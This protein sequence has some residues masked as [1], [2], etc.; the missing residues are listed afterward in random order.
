MLEVEYAQL[1][2]TGR[3]RDHNEDCIGHFVPRTPDEERS[4]GWLFV[5]A[6]GVGGHDRGE[7]ASHTAVESVVRGFAGSHS[8][9]SLISLVP[10][11]VNLANAKVLEAALQY[12]GSSMLTTIVACALRFDR[13]VVSHAGDS[14]CYL[15]RD[16]RTQ[17]LTQ[18]H[19]VTQEQMRL[20]ILSRAESDQATTRNLLSRSLGANL[21]VSVD[22]SEF[23]LM[24]GD[25][26]LLC[27][28]GLHHQVKEADLVAAVHG[29]SKLEDSAA[30]LV[31]LANQRDGTD[32]ISVQL[33]RIRGVERVGMYRGRPNRLPNS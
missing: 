9:E 32:N 25:V 23:S 2:D 28:D 13:V 8:G 31:A 10:R 12:P 17:Q 4:Q 18:D 3:V 29:H 22:T 26:L 20:G 19:T 7:V 27:T 5:T 1:S 30:E 14:R 24:R 6:D 21:F 33:I 11:L 16:L 15:I